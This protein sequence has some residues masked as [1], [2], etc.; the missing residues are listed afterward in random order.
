MFC[1]QKEYSSTQTG[2]ASSNLIKMA[3]AF[4]LFSLLFLTQEVEEGFGYSSLGAG[5]GGGSLVEVNLNV[6][7]WL[8]DLD[9][10]TKEMKAKIKM[11]CVGHRASTV[12]QGLGINQSFTRW[13][14]CVDF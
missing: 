5:G 14:R 3:F 11:D 9:G 1:F 2:L 6:F 7:F 10:G 12:Q 4:S 13:R 8:A